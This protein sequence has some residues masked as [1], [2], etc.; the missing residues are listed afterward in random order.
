MTKRRRRRGGGRLGDQK[1]TE[2]LGLRDPRHDLNQLPLVLVN[3]FR[4]YIFL[5]NFFI[6]HK[7]IDNVH[8]IIKIEEQSGSKASPASRSGPPISKG[9]QKSVEK[10][11]RAAERY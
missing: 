10:D 8:Y 2:A 3:L 1:K 7:D 4:I 5:Q 9:P 6:W 11:T